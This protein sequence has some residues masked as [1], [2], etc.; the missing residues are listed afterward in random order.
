MKSPSFSTLRYGKRIAICTFWR[1][2]YG[3]VRNWEDSRRSLKGLA[4]RSSSVSRS[5]KFSSSIDLA[6]SID[7]FSPSSSAGL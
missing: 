7:A 2:R 5:P 1:S 3:D 6:I 4:L